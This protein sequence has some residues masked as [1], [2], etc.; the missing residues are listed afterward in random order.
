MV[1]T[2]YNAFGGARPLCF[3]ELGYLSPEGL[4]TL[5]SGFEWAASVT[6]A[7]QA[8]WLGRAAQLAR[9]SGK[10]R[11]M[12]VWN[13]DFTAFGADP[14]Q[15][16]RLSVLAVAVRHARRL[17]GR[18]SKKNFTSPPTPLHKKAME[19]GE[20]PMLGIDEGPF[21]GLFSSQP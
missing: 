4:G 16:M 7:Q 10:V 17:P 20:K 14:R 11:L 9:G 2:Y 13:V 18:C 3:T 21:S 8:Q 19:R 15:A 1:N 12:I 5:P 6:V